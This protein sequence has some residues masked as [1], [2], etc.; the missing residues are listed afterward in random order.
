MN[1]PHPPQSSEEPGIRSRDA[2]LRGQFRE[3][4]RHPR[5]RW[6]VIVVA[7]ITAAFSW[8]LR[9]LAIHA[10]RE[11]IHSHILLI[12]LIVL[13]LIHIEW[14]RLPPPEEYRGSALWAT[15]PLLAG[16][17]ALALATS[18][19]RMA[20]TSNLSHNDFL[21]LTTLSY[22]CLVWGSGF[23]LAGRRW[24]KSAAFPIGFLLFLIPLP[25]AFVVKAED[26]L[27]LG[28]A[29]A[30]HW[31]FQ[32][33]GTPVFREGTIFKLPGIVL[34]VAR[35]CSG[36]R[37]TWVL[38]ITSLLASYLFLRNPL[39]RGLLVAF[40]IPLGVLRNGFRILVIGLLC[41]HMGPDMID[42][43]IHKRG[44]PLF[45]ALSLTPLFGL[46]WWLRRRETK[47]QSEQVPARD[48]E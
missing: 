27:V 2:S 47:E 10:T 46:A 39:H 21:A 32:L 20:N 14:H 11:E 29:E 41:V 28:S 3:V 5:S 36:I 19:Q 40:V 1:M 6:F 17:G 34:E 18:T 13:Y 12:P 9:D 4:F 22:I 35:E 48:G 42:S 38:V 16:I 7:V 44:G 15:I 31:L 23:L 8:P 25:D 30:T 24:M 37:S 26:A 33:S 43:I 45:F